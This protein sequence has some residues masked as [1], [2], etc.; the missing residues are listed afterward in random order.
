MNDPAAIAAIL[1]EDAQE[2]V[3]KQLAADLAKTLPLE[4]KALAEDSA[5]YLECLNNLPLKDRKTK[6]EIRD[7]LI[8]F[9][10]VYCHIK[11]QTMPV[12]P[13]PRRPRRPRPLQ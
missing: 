6:Q 9:W 1:L 11:P 10:N 13:R 12:E 3:S 7:G 5:L 4:Q 8:L 2:N